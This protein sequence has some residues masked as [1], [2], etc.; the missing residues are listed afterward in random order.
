MAADQATNAPLAWA[1]AACEALMAAYE[2]AELPP[3]RMWHYHQG[4]FLCG[5]EMLAERTGDERYDRYIRGYVD[6]LVDERGNL[7]F[8]RDEL[9]AVQAGLLLFRLAKQTGLDKYRTAAARL[10]GLFDTLNRT[11]CGGF[12]HKDSLPYNMW[13][14]GLYMGGV[15]GLAYA[16]AY[17][18]EELRGT[19]LLQ[20][21]LMRRHMRDPQTGLLYHA[22]DESRRMPW[23]DPVTGLSPSFWGRSLGWYVLAVAQFIDLLPGEAHAEARSELS[24]ALRETLT[25]LIRYQD[26]DSGLW[27][28]VVD[29][30]DRPD[31]W[32]E[33]SCSSL[34]VYAI[35]VAVRQGTLPPECAEAAQR[36][37][38]GLVERLRQDEH[39]RLVLPDI[40]IGTAA[41][42]YDYYVSRST[43]AND[44][45]GIGAFVMACVAVDALSAGDR[46]PA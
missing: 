24:G 32:L 8:L 26:A 40:C 7:I 31:N 18:D 13:L 34:F 45:H 27:Y 12:W 41:G 38:R 14:D 4:V 6:S 5:M 21:R 22:W 28:Q 25:A 29:K 19:I 1:R 30:G 11:G 3:A 39:G 42:D 33:T 23:A 44:L 2:P 36:G 16:A 43:S 17:G 10:R 35:A 20:E 9:D 37:Y 46:Q 15:F